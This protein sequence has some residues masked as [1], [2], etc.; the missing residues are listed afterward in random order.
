MLVS[1][2][3]NIAGHRAV[4]TK[5][6]RFGVVVRNRGLGGNIAAGLRSRALQTRDAATAARSRLGETNERFHDPATGCWVQVYFKQET[7]ER[8]YVEI[9]PPTN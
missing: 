8:S 2:T 6:T 5:G 1:T 3:E 4:E 9:A 7:G